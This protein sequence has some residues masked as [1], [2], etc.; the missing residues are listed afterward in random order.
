M[1]KKT[2]K[3][4]K[5]LNLY[6]DAP[7]IIKVLTDLE[8]RLHTFF[9]RHVGPEGPKERTREKTVRAAAK[10][11]GGQAPRFFRAAL[12]PLS[13]GQDRQILTRSGSG[14]PELQGPGLF[15]VGQERLILT[16]SGGETKS[17]CILD[18]LKI[19]LR[20]QVLTDLHV[21]ST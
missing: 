20:L 8:N 3:V 1:D 15:P 14:D 11:C 5:D 18:I 6:S 10:P 19:L 16:R 17:C 9:Y 13:V 12:G 7:F 21:Y 4:R 2:P